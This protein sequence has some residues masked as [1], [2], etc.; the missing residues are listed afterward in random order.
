MK[1]IKIASLPEGNSVA[2]DATNVRH[3]VPKRFRDT[4][5]VGDYMLVHDETFSS[6][7]ELNEDG[8]IKLDAKGQPSV[9]A[10]EPWTRS[11]AT[12]IGDFKSLT[13]AKREDTINAGLEDNIVNA[14]IADLKKEFSLEEAVAIA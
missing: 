13:I 10:C 11:T 12:M 8:T 4:I 2:Y 7:T 9:V 14:A 1:T 3:F 6:R 5:K